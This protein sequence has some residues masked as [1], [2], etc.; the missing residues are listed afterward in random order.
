MGKLSFS[1]LLSLILCTACAI[2]TKLPYPTG[3]VRELNL[4]KRSV[5]PKAA[6]PSASPAASAPRY[7]DEYGNGSSH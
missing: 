7:N 4:D 5:N 6:V 3:A 2:Q 1:V